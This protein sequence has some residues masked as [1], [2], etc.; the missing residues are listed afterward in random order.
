LPNVILVDLGLPDISGLEVIASIKAF[1]PL[2][3]IIVLTM[4]EDR[5]HLLAAFRAGASGYLLKGSPA[6]DILAAVR[7]ATAGGSPLSAKIARS[8][9]D[10]LRQC[11]GTAGAPAFT[12]R[13][14]D[15]LRLLATGLSEK[16]LAAKLALSHHTIHTHIGKIYRK[17][18][19]RTK[20][21]ALLKARERGLLD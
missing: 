19:A 16:D 9:V 2:V 14:R 17:L 21:E 18:N 4:H 12:A 10:E 6:V 1:F 7:T 20:T 15:V 8:L 3:E 5:E 13:E 11:A